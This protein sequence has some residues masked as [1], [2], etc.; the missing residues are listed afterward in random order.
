MG[1]HFDRW[2]WNTP[3]LYLDMK[4]FLM[5]FKKAEMF[6]GKVNLLLQYVHQTALACL[7]SHAD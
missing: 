4:N 1:S 3:W 5:V 6:L 2:P 7:S